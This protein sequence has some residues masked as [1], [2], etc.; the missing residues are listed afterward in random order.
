MGNQSSARTSV[1]FDSFVSSKS[2]KLTHSVIVNVAPLIFFFFL[3]LYNQFCW[4]TFLQQPAEHF[5]K[6]VIATNNLTVTAGKEVLGDKTGKKDR[7][8]SQR[9]RMSGSRMTL[10]GPF[11]GRGIEWEDRSELIQAG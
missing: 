8:K 1:T 11:S 9:S 7:D 6:K 4:N 3:F 10:H 2:A 5:V